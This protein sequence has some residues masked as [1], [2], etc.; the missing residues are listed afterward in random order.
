MKNFKFGQR[1]AF[2]RNCAI[3][4][5]H[6]GKIYPNRN[7]IVEKSGAFIVDIESC[8]NI[9][10]LVKKKRLT[11]WVNEYI[12]G[13]DSQFG[14]AYNSEIEA[15]QSKGNFYIRTIKFMECK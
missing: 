1:V 4:V 14:K 11:I 6:T 5:R 10:R 15:K 3:G 8:V 2:S 12:G 7:I 9:K 13:Y